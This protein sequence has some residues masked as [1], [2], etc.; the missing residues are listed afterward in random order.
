MLPG[1]AAG[2]E[3]PLVALSQCLLGGDRQQ[4]S[5][6]RRL[7]REALL[8]SVLLELTVFAAL[9]LVP[10]F[11]TPDFSA[12][13][14]SAPKPV[15]V[16]GNR[17]PGATRRPDLA[18]PR[19]RQEP[20]HG[21]TYCSAC[22]PTRHSTL[23]TTASPEPPQ[24]EPGPP[25]GGPLPAGLIPIPGDARFSRRADTPQQPQGE[26]PPRIRISTIEPG[27]L[28][29]RVEPVYPLLPL[30]MRREGRVELSAIIAADGTIESLEVVSGDPLFYGSALEAVRQWRYRPTILNGLPVEVETR[31]VL[32]YRLSQ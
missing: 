3:K 23:P 8:L 18:N 10:L 13:A 16:I 2:E 14:V 9:V 4:F 30:H 12:V 21:I 29:P 11:A 20:V 5:R 27:M 17:G 32:L 19:L 15:Y 31:I 25:Y 22:A 6:E 26:R 24:L 1:S 28:Q 7:R